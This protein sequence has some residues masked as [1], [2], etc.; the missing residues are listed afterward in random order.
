VKD[1]AAAALAASK[2]LESFLF[3]MKPNDPVTL[4]KSVVTW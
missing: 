2:L 1:T 4:I 3:G